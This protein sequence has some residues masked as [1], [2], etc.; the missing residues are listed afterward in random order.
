MPNYDGAFDESL[1]LPARLSMAL[2]NGV[3]GIAMGTAAEV[4]SHNLNE[5]TQ[6][7]TALLKRPMLETTDL[8]QYILTPDPTGDG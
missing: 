5:A 3:L 2:S 1:H 8:T 6:A 4:L 7:A